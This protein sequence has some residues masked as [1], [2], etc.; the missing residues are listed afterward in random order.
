LICACFGRGD[1][2]QCEADN[3]FYADGMTLVLRDFSRRGHLL[4]PRLPLPTKMI[5]RSAADNEREDIGKSGS[6]FDKEKREQLQKDAWSLLWFSF[7]AMNTFPLTPTVL[8]WLMKN[9]PWLPRHWIL[10]S[11]F[12][13]QRLERFRRARRSYL[14]GK[15][16]SNQGGELSRTPLHFKE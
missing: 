8:T 7:L 10:P 6:L 15:T 9:A 13:Q 1:R 11:Q 14:R 2:E 5:A 16:Q 12:E 4:L 3:A